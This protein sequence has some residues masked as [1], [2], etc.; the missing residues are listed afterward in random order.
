MLTNWINKKSWKSADYT[1]FR[2]HVN[3]E[4]KANLSEANQT[5]IMDKVNWTYWID[6]PGF[7]LDANL[8]FYTPV[9]NETQ[10]LAAEYIKLGGKKSPANFKEYLEWFPNEKFLFL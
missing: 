3:S 7:P 4:V 8:T 10:S 9:V 2:A 5:Y 6:T 1:E